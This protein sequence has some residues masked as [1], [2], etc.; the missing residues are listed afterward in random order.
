MN[1][2]VIMGIVAILITGFLVLPAMSKGLKWENGEKGPSKQAGKSNI[3]HLYLYEK[4]PDPYLTRED[5]WL[6]VEGG[7]WGKMKYNLSGST[8]DFV[9]NGHGLPIGQEYTLIYYP[10]PWPGTGLIC[11]GSGIVTEC[12]EDC[13]EYYSSG[14]IH[15]KGSVE[16]GTLPIEADENFENGAKIFLVPSSDVSCEENKMIGWTEDANLYEGALI[17]FDDTDEQ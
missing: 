13:I 2:K 15:I 1:K 10:D 8:F 9:F 4:A 11:L 5:P 16:T 17:T 6:I 12:E 7:M 3:G 14:N